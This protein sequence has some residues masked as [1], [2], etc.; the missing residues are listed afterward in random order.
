MRNV[1]MSRAVLAVLAAGLLLAVLPTQA[2]AQAGPFQ[3]HSLTPCRLVDTRNVSAPILSTGVTRTFSVQGVCAVPAGAKAASINVTAVRPN[4]AGHLTLFPTGGSVPTVSTVNFAANEPAIANGA[5]VP[6]STATSNDLSVSP[7]V[8]A[9]GGTVH[10][11]IDVTG[12]F[13]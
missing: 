1:A 4:G 8:A 10:L 12:Y 2:A 7:Y 13:Q 5:I 9:T 6:L 11:V 3:Y